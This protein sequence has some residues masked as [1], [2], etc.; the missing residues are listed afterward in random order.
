MPTFRGHKTILQVNHPRSLGQLPP[1]SWQR[2]AAPRGKEMT[3]PE[4]LMNWMRE[5]WVSPLPALTQLQMYID[6]WVPTQASNPAIT[7]S[8][9]IYFFCSKFEGRESFIAL[10]KNQ[11][12]FSSVAC[13][14]SI[15]PTGLHQSA[16][17]RSF[18]PTCARHCARLCGTVVEKQTRSLH[19]GA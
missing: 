14:L 4:W 5:L 12:Q 15:Y 1:G 7:E 13:L 18:S 3:I 19:C 6:L 10:N 2:N 16:D 9:I 11:N 8:W 17:K